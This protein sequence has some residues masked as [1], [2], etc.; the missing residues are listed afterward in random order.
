ATAVIY[1]ASAATFFA[2]LQYHG[3]YSSTDGITWTRLPNQPGSGLTTAACPAQAS[4]TACPIFRGEIAVVPG[5]N[6]MYVWYVDNDDNDEG[7]WESTNGGAIWTQ[8]SDQGIA[9]CGDII[10]CGTLDG[11][12]N[13]ELGAVPNGG[14]T[15][16]YAGAVNLYKCQINYASPTC[17]GTG[18]N[19][20]LNL[21]HVYGCSAIAKV[22]PAQHALAFQLLNN[23]TQVAMYFANDGGIYRTLDGFSDLTTGACGEGTNN[24]DSL[25]QTLGSMTQFVTFSQ[26]ADG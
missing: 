3:F 10:G 16:L 15:D 14:A 4:S 19:T 5:R 6:E 9:Y 25:N 11:T 1:N 22:H 21:T 26:S 18:S 24:F 17:N 23:N 8:I 20:F 2:A 13:L 12:Y 7:I